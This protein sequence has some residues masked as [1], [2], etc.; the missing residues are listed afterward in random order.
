MEVTLA[1]A[2]HYYDVTIPRMF[3]FQVMSS[4]KPGLSILDI[5]C[6]TLQD[7]VMDFLLDSVLTQPGLII[8]RVNPRRPN[9]KISDLSSYC[10]PLVSGEG[11]TGLEPFSS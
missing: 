3:K 6:F 1:I 9:D 2:C 10:L 11:L 7:I 5:C 4:T 8:T